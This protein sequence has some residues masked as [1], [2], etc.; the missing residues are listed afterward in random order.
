[1]TLQ[2]GPAWLF[3]PADRPERFAKAAAAAGIGYAELVQRLIRFPLERAT[4]S[5]VSSGRA[6]T[7]L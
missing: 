2:V 1:M 6:T 5:V 4:G 7:I 3:C